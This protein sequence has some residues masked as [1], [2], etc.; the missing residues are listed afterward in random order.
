MDRQ[1][2]EVV[3][4]GGWKG[5]DNRSTQRQLEGLSLL[6]RTQGFVAHR[7]NA[8]GHGGKVHSG[9]MSFDEVANELLRPRH[10]GVKMMVAASRGGIVVWW[11][12][13][14]N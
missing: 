11:Q 8:G 10:R 9:H 14:E 3:S 6:P 12:Q 4:S 2:R 1:V 13:M 5:I 7:A